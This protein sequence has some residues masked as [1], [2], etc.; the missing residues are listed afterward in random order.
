MVWVS[1]STECAW[2]KDLSWGEGGFFDL[3]RGFDG[4]ICCGVGWKRV[5]KTR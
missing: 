1:V 2:R 5:M 3:L 4:F